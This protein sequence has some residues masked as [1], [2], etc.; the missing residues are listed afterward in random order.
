MTRRSRPERADR[1]REGRRLAAAVRRQDDARLAR[2]PGAARRRVVG[3]RR[4]LVLTGPAERRRHRHRRPVRGL[5][6]GDRLAGLARG[7]TAASCTASETDDGVLRD[8]PRAIRSSTTRATPTARTPRPRPGPA[9]PSTPRRRTPRKPV[10]EWNL[11][12]LVVKG[13][14]VEHWLNGEKVV[15]STRLAATSGSKLVAASKFKA[16]PAYGTAHKGPH[17]LQ[18]HG[19]HVSFRNIKVRVIGGG[20]K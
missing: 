5:R 18:D 11:T 8:R 19:D 6:A 3:H 16:M 7:P 14:H 1:R 17:R 13:N 15:A 4:R 9:T 10:G 20:D 2:L 12:R